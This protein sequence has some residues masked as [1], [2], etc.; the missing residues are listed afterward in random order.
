MTTTFTAK[1]ITQLRQ[2]ASKAAR[3]PDDVP[4]GWSKSAVDPMAVLA[5]FKPLR[6][7]E[8]YVLRAYQFREGGNG[9]GFV[10]AM[11]VDAEFPDPEEC[12]RIQGM[13]LEPP[14]P[15]LALDDIMDGIDGEGSPWSYM[16]AS[17]FARAI[18]EFGAMWHGCDWD[19]YHLLDD[20]PW[21]ETE[22]GREDDVKDPTDSVVGKKWLQPRPSSWNP[23]VTQDG[24]RVTVTFFTLS[25]LGGEV[26]YRHMDVYTP[27]SY[28][29]E[30]KREQVATGG[31]GFVF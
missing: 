15:P 8:G 29:F 13:F 5:V 10:W 12:P 25:E 16:C 11:P 30:A 18:S 27:G 23:Q 4:E 17:F 26:I 19:T 22:T 21:K 20:D 1:K 2:E 9:N 14:K 28:K 31:S 6:I 3:L 7:K 24:D